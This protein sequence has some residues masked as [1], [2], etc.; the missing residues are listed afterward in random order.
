MSAE[1]AGRLRALMRVTSGDETIA[2][3]LTMF[4]DDAVRTLKSTGPLP[5]RHVRRVIGIRAEV[6][7][8]K[9]IRP[10]GLDG[11]IIALDCATEKAVE[12]HAFESENTVFEVLTD[13]PLTKVLGVL[14][15]PGRSLTNY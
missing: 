6:A 3:C 11:V 13:S 9:A 12:L 8:E 10:E 4:S 14:I 2:K 7:S 1:I 5:I 15:F